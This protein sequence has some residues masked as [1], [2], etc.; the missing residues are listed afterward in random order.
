MADRADIVLPPAPMAAL[1]ALAAA[2]I[3]DLDAVAAVVAEHPTFL[4][5]WQHPSNRGFLRCLAGLRDAAA[6]IGETTEV[7]RIGDFLTD[8]DPGWDD[9]NLTG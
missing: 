7:E 1:E 4:V 9:V 3:D 2:P 6:E 5:R 8:L